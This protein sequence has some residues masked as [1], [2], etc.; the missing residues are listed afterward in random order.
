MPDFAA[1]LVLSCAMSISKS[2]N[3]VDGAFG[4]DPTQGMQEARDLKLPGIITE[5]D[6]L[7]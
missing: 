5:N 7:L 1:D 3:F 4:V 6:Q 2:D